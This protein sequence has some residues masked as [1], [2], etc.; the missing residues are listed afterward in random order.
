MVSLI[1]LLRRVN[2]G[3]SS[4]EPKRGAA[5][6]IEFQ[7]TVKTIQETENR[8]YITVHLY[9]EKSTSQGYDLVFG[10]AITEEGKAYLVK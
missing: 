6:D 7:H 9:H 10:V 4:F 1:E 3:E 5:G 2:N 8:G